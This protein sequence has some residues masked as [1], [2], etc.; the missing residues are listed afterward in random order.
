MQKVDILER[1][2]AAQLTMCVCMCVCVSVCVCMRAT[3]TALLE[4]LKSQ[5]STKSTLNNHCK[6]DFWER[7]DSQT[8]FWEFPQNRRAAAS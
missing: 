7:N 6:A 4:I 2:L 1:C 8:D 3:A 5:L